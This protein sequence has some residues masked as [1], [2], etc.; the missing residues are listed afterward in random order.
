ME[1]FMDS[2]YLLDILHVLKD[3]SK[4]DLYRHL[5]LLE[6][7]FNVPEWTEDSLDDLLA[8]LSS[9]GLVTLDTR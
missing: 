4:Q 8:E 1:H 3:C 6:T 9:T 2:D 7:F 5:I